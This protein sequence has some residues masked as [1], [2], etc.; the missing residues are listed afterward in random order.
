MTDDTP[1]GWLEPSR[2]RDWLKIDDE[3]S[4]QADLAETIRQAVAEW[5]EAQRPDLDPNDFG[6]RLIQ[7]GLLAVGRVFGRY[8]KATFSELGNLDSTIGGD[9]DLVRLIGKPRP[10]LG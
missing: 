4:D 7:A 3:A 1:H 10:V 6:P 5:I 9:V 2:V 8:D